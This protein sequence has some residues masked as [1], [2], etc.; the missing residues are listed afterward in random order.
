LKD[1]IINEIYENILKPKLEEIDKE[2][3]ENSLETFDSE[4]F[5][6]DLIKF[7]KEDKKAFD[8]QIKKIAKQI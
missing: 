3:I 5:N 4:D 6:K 8:K 2:F 1:K 7:Y